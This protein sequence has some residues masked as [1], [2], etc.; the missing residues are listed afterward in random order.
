MCGITGIYNYGDLNR[1]VD[2]PLLERMTRTLAHR[3]PDGEGFHIEGPIGFGHRRLAIVDLSPTGAQP[4]ESHGRWITYNGELYNHRVFRSELKGVSFRG[5]SDTE[6]I[7]ELL[8]EQGP[9]AL[10]R[11]NGIF[12][13]G[14]W[15]REKRALTLARD[16]LGVKQVYYYDDGERLLFASEIKAL[17]ASPDVPRELDVE[18]LNQYLHFHTPLFERTFFRG[19]HQ[20]RPGEYLTV[21]PDRRRSVKY[22]RVTDL[23]ARSLSAEQ[24]VEEL[25]DKLATVVSDQLMSDVPVGAFFSGGIDSSAVAAFAK[26]AGTAPQCFGVHFSSQG[27]IDERPYQEAAAKALGLELHLTTLDGSTFPSDLGKLLYQQDQPVIGPAFLPMYYVSK[28]AS[29]HVKVCLGGQAADELFGG[30]A[31]YALARPD[32]LVKGWFN[33]RREARKVAAPVVSDAPPQARVGGN[34]WRQ[35]RDPKTLYRIARNVRN[36]GDW[37]SLYFENFAKISEATWKSVFDSPDIVSRRSCRDLYDE[38]LEQFPSAEPATRLMHWDL[39]TYLPGLFQQ[40]DRM[41]M[42]NSLESRVPLADPRLVQFAF[43]TGVDMKLRDGASKWIL[44]QAVADAIPE[45]VLNR[46]KVGF[47]TPVERWMRQTHSGFVRDVLLSRTA[48]ER[49]LWNPKTLTQLLDA[50]RS[51][52]FANDVLWKVLCVETWARTFL[53]H[54]PVLEKHPIENRTLDTPRMMPPETV[55]ACPGE[56][57]LK[58]VAQELRELGGEGTLFRV[59]WEVKQ[60][61]GLT[62]SSERPL[63]LDPHVRPPAPM[64]N[65][66]RTG[67]VAEVMRSLIAPK[68]LTAL[69]RLAEH[70]VEG[71][72]QSFSRWDAEFGN[73]IDWQ[74]NPVTGRRWDRDLHW[75][76]ALSLERD[77]GDVKTTW[78]VARFPQAYWFGRAAAFFPELAENLAQTFVEQVRQFIEANPPRL[79]IHWSSGQE[80]VLRSMSW[81]FGFSS[82]HR[83]S[84]MRRVEG[85]MG[86]YLLAG[87]EHVEQHRVYAENAVHNN[88][89]LS[90]SLG[91]LMEGLLWP[92]RPGALAK[93]DAGLSLLTREAD[94]QFY[95]DGGYLQQSHTYSRAAMQTYL[96][97]GRIV[98]NAGLEVPAAWTRALERSLDFLLERQSAKDGSLPNYG[99]NDG[100]HP[101]LV[102]TCDFTD[103][104]P[105]LQLASVVTRGERLYEPGPWDE[106]VVWFEGPSALTLPLRKPQRAS[107]NA[108]VY[109]QQVLRG[110]S[111]ETF[112]TLRC[113]TLKDRFSQIDMLHMDVYWRGHN[114]LIDGG[115]YQYN[116]NE[117]WH[118]HFLGTASHNTVQLDGRDQMLHFRRFKNLYWPRAEVLAFEDHPEWALVEG[119]HHGYERH[120]GACLHRRS[121]LFAKDDLWIVIDRIEGTGEHGLRLQW[122]LADFPNRWDPERAALELE[123]PSGPLSV[124]LLDS[125]G[126]P[127]PSDLVRGRAQPP[128]GWHSRYYGE[129]LPTPSLVAAQTRVVPATWFTVIAAGTPTVSVGEGAWRVHSE[130]S[131]ISFVLRG[132]RPTDIIV[133]RNVDR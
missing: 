43:R 93:R 51:L 116:A 9:D 7:L 42:A 4:M 59:Q 117:S 36:L 37:K 118:H 10:S 82:L 89:L 30:Y 74:L 66:T 55:T 99:A 18:A 29:D 88:H 77:V 12:G 81:M 58:D 86:S 21:Q 60:R 120:P 6:T 109:G 28:L 102:T 126:L 78:E 40:D 54:N 79:G 63:L 133:E 113:G 106:G 8:I 97:A 100:S 64:V 125:N 110:K 33:S 131:A 112:S 56:K 85:L 24:Q 2:R 76:K 20:V 62:E 14:F 80:L 38:T 41:S 27:V 84:S 87:F 90:E 132:E 49:G 127:L 65:F 22:W 68:S 72:I 70:A 46:R 3:G 25:R 11:A 94:V 53:D 83:F 75:S 31:R 45:M 16:P 108:E 69:R 122:L 98:R 123:T 52:P 13:L 39:Q 121:V 105:V 91:T 114:V 15:D 128:R 96:W 119:Q 92:E 32:L 107:R 111:D 26:R 48:R 104:R 101:V 61:F 67:E 34:L 95:P 57:S 50:P 73:P 44:R 47:D 17:F 71:R 5:S 1:P 124:L 19:I 103:F 115:S 130:S 23:H 129:K 35:L